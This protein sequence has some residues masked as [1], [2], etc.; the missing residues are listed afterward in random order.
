MY[1]GPRAEA[2]SAGRRRLPSRWMTFRDGADTTNAV[3]L[4]EAKD[5]FPRR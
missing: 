1:A 3:I 4:S 5:L 2:A